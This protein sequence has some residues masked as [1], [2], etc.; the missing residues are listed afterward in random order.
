VPV[1]ISGSGTVRAPGAAVW[2][3]MTDRDTLL[4]AFPRIDRLDVTGNGRYEFTVTIPIAA[5]SGT[6]SG[7]AV[8]TSAD[9]PSQFVARVSAAG[10]RG[11]VDAGLTVRLEPGGAGGTELSYEADAEVAGPIA[12]IGQRLLASIAERLATDFIAGLDQAGPP[13]A[14]PVEHAQRLPEH[15]D[16][17]G[18]AFR[19]GLVVA[20]A[21]GMAGMLVGALLGRRSRAQ[22]HGKR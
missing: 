14:R 13:A 6:Y 22:A 20:G 4:R 17:P 3:A 21:A 2:A 9:P 8:L 19:A 1:R 11:T 15:R 7:E 12:G 16:Q 10:A 5:V 18:S